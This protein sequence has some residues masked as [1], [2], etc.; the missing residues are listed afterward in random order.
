MWAL[1]F[2]LQFGIQFIISPLRMITTKPSPLGSSVTGTFLETDAQST[3]DRKI[4]SKT[5]YSVLL[6]TYNE[7]ENL[8]IITFL[9]I[10][11]FEKQLD[12]TDAFI[13]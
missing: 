12:R 9:L 6:P 3:V 5:L 2:K 7:V 1:K 10:E 11:T 13:F 4:K 8:P